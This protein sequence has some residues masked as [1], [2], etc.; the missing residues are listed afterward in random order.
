M[1]VYVGVSLKAKTEFYPFNADALLYSG[2]KGGASTLIASMSVYIGL[3]GPA[4]PAWA[5][6][7]PFLVWSLRHT[8][9]G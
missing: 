3:V 2:L 8:W 6:C 4:L 9:A 5:A 7:F 1:L